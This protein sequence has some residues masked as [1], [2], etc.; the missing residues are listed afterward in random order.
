MIHLELDNH[1]FRTDAVLVRLAS[2]LHL[3]ETLT[4]YHGLRQTL[5][6]ALL[7]RRQQELLPK[8]VRDGVDGEDRPR[9]DVAGH[10]LW[11]RE[12]CGKLT[13]SKLLQ[14]GQGDGVGFREGDGVVDPDEFAP[15]GFD[16]GDDVIDRR[17]ALVAHNLE[18]G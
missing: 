16:S 6:G 12:N 2:L 8:W 1:L 18:G 14:N 11:A 9:L 7:Q 13:T 4:N 3:L 17:G 5:D 15:R 10:V